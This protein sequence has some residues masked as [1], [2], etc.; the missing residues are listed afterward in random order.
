VWKAETIPD[1]TMNDKAQILFDKWGEP[2]VR[3]VDYPENGGPWRQFIASRNGGTWRRE[4]IGIEGWVDQLLTHRDGTLV[5]LIRNWDARTVSLATRDQSGWYTSEILTGTAVSSVTAT[6]DSAGK[7]HI[8]YQ[9]WENGTLGYLTG[10][11]EHW[12]TLVVDRS[13]DPTGRAG[14]GCRVAQRPDGSIVLAYAEYTDPANYTGSI[15]VARGPAGAPPPIPPAGSGAA[16]L[17]AQ[18]ILTTVVFL[19]PAMLG[20]ILAITRL[21]RSSAARPPPV[22]S[23]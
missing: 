4:D 22:E 10:D 9:D 14:V 3:C 16:P 18:A 5:G 21:R 11:D 13:R 8:G 2:M 23:S 12:S 6:L 7:F 20:L 15:K 1:C 19:P 17:L